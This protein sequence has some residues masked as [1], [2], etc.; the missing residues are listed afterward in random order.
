MHWAWMIW[1]G[2]A[3]AQNVPA[4]DGVL[5]EWAHKGDDGK[6]SKAMS[7]DAAKAMVSGY[8][9]AGLGVAPALESEHTKHLAIDMTI[10]WTGDLEIKKKD[11]TEVTITSSP[12]TGM[13]ADLATV[14]ATYGVIKYNRRGTDKPHWSSTGA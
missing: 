11:N 13:N 6:Y 5:I 4:M 12:K 1:K 14:G 9:I 8:D 3:D 7:V 10:G 2:K